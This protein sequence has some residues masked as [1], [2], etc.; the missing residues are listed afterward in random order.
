MSGIVL[1]AAVRQNLLSL[2]STADLLSQTQ[3]RLASG[4]K[5]NSA[6]DNPTNFFTAAGLNS[7]ASDLNNLLDSMGTAI[8]T[9]E[10]ADN[11]I[12]SITK[13][14]ESGQALARQAQQTQVASERSSLAAQFDALRTQIDQL[15]G[16]A[17]FNGTNL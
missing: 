7:R 13:L 4:K 12:S 10:A 6:L 5:V 1:S 14:V 17:G 15:A 3:N 8:K 9:L 16:D 2:Q 11:G